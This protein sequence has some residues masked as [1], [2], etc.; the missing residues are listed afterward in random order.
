MSAE[1]RTLQDREVE[2]K[3]GTRKLVQP[4]RLQLALLDPQVRR[5]LRVVAVDLLDE[6]F[7]IFTHKTSMESPGGLVA[8]SE[9]ST[10]A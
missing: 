10:T 2:V 5:K 8:E 4:A 3:V 1:E 7:G 9:S 6:A